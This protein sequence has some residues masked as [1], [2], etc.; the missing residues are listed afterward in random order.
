[1]NDA[2]YFGCWGNQAGH[3]LHRQDGRPPTGDDYATEYYRQRRR[4]IDASL[5]PRLHRRTGQLIWTGMQDKPG[6]EYSSD[7]VE[8]GRYFVHHL[9]NDY[10][11]MAWWDRTQGGTRGACNSVVL[12]KGAWSA[13]TMLAALKASFPPVLANLTRAGVTLIDAG[14]PPPALPLETP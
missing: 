13:E 1:M 7:E 3:H 6:L 11:A 14:P 8:Q 4:H 2:L 9:D 5:P 12:I 10:T